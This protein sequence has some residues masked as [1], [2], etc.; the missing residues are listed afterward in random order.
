[1]LPEMLAT[2][3]VLAL[4]LVGSSALATSSAV[5]IGRPANVRVHLLSPPL[6]EARWVAAR[7]SM[8]FM[9]S[10]PPSPLPAQESGNNKNVFEKAKNVLSG[11]G[12][13]G[14]LR[15]T[16]DAL[17]KL[18]LNALLAYGFVSNVSY[19]TCVILAWVAFGKS[20]GLSPLAAGQWKSFLLVYAGFFAANN[21][22]R[23]LRFSLS[24]VITP[25]FDRV[26][27]ALQRRT[28]LSRPLCTG[29]T[30]FLVNVCG[31][32]SYLVGGL[33]LATS[34][35]GVPLLAT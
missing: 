2:V 5:Q 14:N 23:P 31:T 27:D 29:I 21:V 13:S 30:V 10:S 18:G 22:L 17:A 15:I 32:V 11:N 26:I 28:Q 19:I 7:S 6:K 9:S 1:M 3:L 4:A 20:T 8:L 25:A 24:L 12:L 16:K 35:A 33:F 34:L